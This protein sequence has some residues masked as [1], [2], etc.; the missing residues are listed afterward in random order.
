M[1]R[2]HALLH[3]SSEKLREARKEAWEGKNSGSIR[4]L[5][6]NLRWERR[7]I[8]FL[9]LSG[10]SRVVEDGRDEDQAWAERMDGRIAWEA[11]ERMTARGEG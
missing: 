4:V 2:S 10:V 6:S 11:E 9:E 3:C 8:K 1:T 5:L 7:L